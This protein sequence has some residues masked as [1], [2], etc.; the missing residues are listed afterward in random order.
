M[1]VM[2]HFYMYLTF[3]QLFILT[4]TGCAYAENPSPTLNPV[5]HTNI[6]VTVS[7]RG[8]DTKGS[9][10][11]IEESFISVIATN[12]QLSDVVIIRNVQSNES[13]ERSIKAEVY[14]PTNE[15]D[16]WILDSQTKQRTLIKQANNAFL[17][18]ERIEGENGGLR[19]EY[20]R[21]SQH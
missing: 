19:T 3:I 6:K 14:I 17:I 21:L 11:I 4:I 20:F 15:E 2:K 5:F 1:R 13:G 9:G 12:N 10:D 8:W 18:T 7:L 16:V